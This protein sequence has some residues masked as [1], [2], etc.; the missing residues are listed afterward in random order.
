MSSNCPLEAIGFPKD[1]QLQIQR[2]ASSL[3]AGDLKVSQ[4]FSV[5]KLGFLFAIIRD[6]RF[7]RRRVFVCLCT[8]DLK[9]NIWQCS[10]SFAEERRQG[11]KKKQ[12][13]RQREE[14]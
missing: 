5:A 8:E 13:K 2:M 4:P 6:I 9:A 3:Y 1:S 12:K 10:R 14:V 7:K 11:G